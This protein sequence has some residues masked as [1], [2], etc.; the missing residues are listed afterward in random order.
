M[1]DPI[2]AIIRQLARPLAPEPTGER[3]LLRPLEGVRAVMFDVY[4]TLFISAVG[5][6][7]TTAS[8][9]RSAA[10]DTATAL[11]GLV[12]P[13]RG[14]DLVSHLDWYIEGRH[15]QAR[16]EG[17]ASPE[18]DILAEWFNAFDDLVGD[19]P[20]EETLR[21]LATVFENLV[22]PVWPMPGCRET[23][24][25][26]RDAGFLLGVISN[27]QFYTPP[28]FA[29]LLGQSRESLGLNED[30][31]FYS[32]RYGRAKPGLEIYRQAV[33]ALQ[34][35]GIAA[36][37]V[38]FVGNDLLNDV[39]AAQAAGFRA[40]LFAGDA[41]S[42]RKREGD[43]RVAGVVPDVIITELAQLP[44]VLGINPT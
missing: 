22:N 26:L 15:R 30:L 40:A 19:V 14:A 41:R 8:G 9:D 18:V 37:D 17:V 38:L 36:S 7:G 3:A 23:L 5:E 13:P 6:I 34:K 11:C 32:Y 4:G 39:A 16:S 31:E 43:D 20:D 29:A 44:G 25:R 2:A 33:D 1:H 27:A 10:C 12:D 21:R 24:E 28:L 42:L 35:R